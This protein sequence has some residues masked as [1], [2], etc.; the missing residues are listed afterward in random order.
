MRVHAIKHVPY[1]GPGWI[2]DWA[3]ARSHDLKEVEITT[4]ENVPGPTQS[5]FLILLGGPMSVH[6]GE[7]LPWMQLERVRLAD[8]IATGK[9]VLGIGFGAQLLASVL[10]GSVVKSDVREIGWYD[11]R[12]KRETIRSFHW[13]S[14]TFTLPPDT[15]SIATSDLTVV[16]GFHRGSKVMGLQFHPEVTEECVRKLIENCGG[17]IRPG[18]EGEQSA[19]QIL[20]EAATGCIGHR[21]FMFKILDLMV[22]R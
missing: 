18:A 20:A 1:E 22:Q 17:E 19:Q 8:F 7:K 21:A 2:T 11:V 14:E 9:P 13:H 12:L 10:G 3:F 5:D 4:G 6:D 16:Q 15:L